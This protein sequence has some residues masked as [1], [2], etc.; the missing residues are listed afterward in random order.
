MGNFITEANAQRKWYAKIASFVSFGQYKLG[1]NNGNILVQDRASGEILEERMPT[2]IKLGIRVLYRVSKTPAENKRVK[3][4]LYAM[5][6]KQGQKYT[7]PSSR[8]EI[9]PFINFHRLNEEEILEPIDSFP[10]FNEFF[11]RKLKPGARYLG[12]PDPRVAVSPAD[13]RVMV[14]PTISAAQELWIKG[15]RFTIGRLF[16]NLLPP[17]EVAAYEAGS[18]AIFRLAPQDYHRFHIPVDGILSSP[19][20]I[21]GQYYTVNPMAIRSSLDVYGENK[22]CFSFIDSTHHGRVAIVC[23]GAM[24]VGSII[25]TSTPGSYISR[26]DEHGYFAFGGSTILVLFQENTITFDKDLVKNS[27]KKLETL[28]RVGNTIGTTKT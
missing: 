22:R 1:T 19:T 14:F 23:I 7:D 13:S 3:K 25:L 10:N 12:S 2:Y 15:H 6:A 16:N 28:L 18:L 27:E 17:E 21:D 5:S 4:M 9:Q 20:N 11:Y 26:L 8:R 24:L